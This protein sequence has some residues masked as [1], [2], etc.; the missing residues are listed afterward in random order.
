MV[1]EHLRHQATVALLGAGFRTKQRRP[2]S[3]ILWH[4]LP[5]HVS[6]PH[7]LEERPLVLPPV[8]ALAIGITNL[9]TGGKQRLMLV[10]DPEDPLEEE[11]KV[12]VLCE[13]RKLSPSILADI[14][15][16]LDT[17]LLEEPEELLRGFLGKANREER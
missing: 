3:E 5:K 1:R 10:R 2:S 11:G 12:G 15:N 13:S 4:D 6:L 9:R 8:A 14:H 17:C 16:L 7:Q